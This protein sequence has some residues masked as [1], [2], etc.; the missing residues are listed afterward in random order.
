MLLILQI[1]AAIVLA[2][3]AIASAP[4]LLVALLS[5]VDKFLEHWFRPMMAIICGV[6]A[7]AAVV[8]FIRNLPDSLWVTLTI[9][10]VILAFVTLSLIREGELFATYRDMR[11]MLKKKR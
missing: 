8:S 7:L 4:F 2:V 5:A 1:A 6:L 3:V 11:K 10:G 9:I